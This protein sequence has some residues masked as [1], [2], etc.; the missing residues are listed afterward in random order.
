[1]KC[2]PWERDPDPERY[3]ARA[4]ADMLRTREVEA[5][6]SS[7]DLGT[8]DAVRSYA[9]EIPTALLVHNA[10]LGVAAQLARDHGHAWL[11]PDRASVLA[12]PHAVVSAHDAGLRVDVWTVDDP[13]EMRSLAAAGVDAI[14]TNVPDVAVAALTGARS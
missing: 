11:H 6:I 1:V 9:P 5:I 4:A 10:D 7:F 8:V 12:A 2:L 3:V 13:D 14:I